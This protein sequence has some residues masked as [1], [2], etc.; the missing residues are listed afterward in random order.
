MS[1]QHKDRIA[2]AVKVTTE[3]GRQLM[4]V[5]PWPGRTVGVTRDGG[6]HA[7]V[8]GERITLT[9]AAGEQLFLAP[10]A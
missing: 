9:T 1:A 2:Q 4:I 5:N 6:K 10:L 3:K 7:R 8:T